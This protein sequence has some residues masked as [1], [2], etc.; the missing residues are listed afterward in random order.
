MRHPRKTW[1]ALRAMAARAICGGDCEEPIDYANALCFFIETWTNKT[2]AIQARIG[3]PPE[4]FYGVL[5]RV[6]LVCGHSGPTY[7]EWRITV[8]D[9]I[10][11]VAQ[12]SG[13]KRDE[14]EGNLDSVLDPLGELGDDADERH[15]I[16]AYFG[17]RLLS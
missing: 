12:M 5:R 6:R 11:A 14:A 2:A 10:A 13:T 16:W 4:E 15:D 3:V 17:P 7:E 9:E 1:L 8:L